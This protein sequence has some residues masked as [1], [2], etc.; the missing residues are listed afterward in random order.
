MTIEQKLPPVPGG[1]PA[2]LAWDEGLGA[3]VA[4]RYDDVAEL[5]RSPDFQPVDLADRLR[6]LGERSGHSYS[7]LVMLFSGVLFFR[8]GPTHAAGRRFLKRAIAEMAPQLGE[9]AIRDAVGSVLAGCGAQGEV[10]AVAD[11]GVPIPLAV[12]SRALQVSDQT[13]AAVMEH[14]LGMIDAWQRLPLRVY[15]DLEARSRA[16]VEVIEAEI[17]QARAHGN[18]RLSRI[19]EL[20]DREPAAEPGQLTAAVFFL[21][22][23]GLETTASL[24]STVAMMHLADPGLRGRLDADRGLIPA[25]VE[26][27]IRLASPL[28]QAN[29]RV[30]RMRTQLGQQVI[31]AGAI[32]TPMLGRCGRDPHA[33]GEPDR[34]RLDRGGPPSLAFGAGSHACLGSHIARLEARVLTEMLVDDYR[35]RPTGSPVE[36]ETSSRFSG[37]PSA[38]LRLRTLRLA[39][40]PARKA[41]VGSE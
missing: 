39:I 37:R 28:R 20:H 17:D 1:A 7:H 2:P 3:W 23:T 38:I 21:L 36:W 18:T 12:M 41:T 27:A 9:T 30:A 4:S 14:G 29:G 16:M 22:W 15:A 6:D 25:A 40:S 13:A 5:L 10:D 8:S 19:I 34:F 35:I 33:Y 11:I 24:L 32:V 26:E 31:E